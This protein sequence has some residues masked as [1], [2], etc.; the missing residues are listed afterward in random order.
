MAA[1]LPLNCDQPDCSHVLMR[2]VM[3]GRAGMTSAWLS[4]QMQCQSGSSGLQVIPLAC[5]LLID[6]FGEACHCASSCC[7]WAELIVTVIGLIQ[8][9][10]RSNCTA[11][12]LWGRVGRQL[13]S[14][15]TAQLTATARWHCP[16]MLP[17]C[18]LSMPPGMSTWQP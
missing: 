8:A 3:Q 1:I 2:A 12:I 17:A 11:A 7:T 5:M 9:A 13:M 6:K 18:V 14:G 15:L 16:P 4:L 10:I